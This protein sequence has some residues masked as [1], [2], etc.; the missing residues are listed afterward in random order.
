MKWVK[1]E[2]RAETGAT[3]LASR[4]ALHIAIP[5]ALLAAP[6]TPFTRLRPSILS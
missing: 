6:I 3:T 5:I 2:I 4:G 1:N